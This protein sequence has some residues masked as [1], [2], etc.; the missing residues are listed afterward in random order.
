[1]PTTTM[2]T[3]TMPT[4][5]MPSKP[6]PTITEEAVLR[7]HLHE[8]LQVLPNN[9]PLYNETQLLGTLYHNPQF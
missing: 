6:M 5:T 9:L 4:T 3:T 7:K 1:M 8:I 2:P